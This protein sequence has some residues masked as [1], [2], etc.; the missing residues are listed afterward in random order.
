MSACELIARTGFPHAAF[1]GQTPDEV[2]FG[3][4][5]PIPS[6]LAARRRDA[7]R[8]RVARNRAVACAACPR[9]RPASSEHLAA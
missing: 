6:E 9:G 1:E 8:E 7:R 2:S 3:R 5:D 4:G